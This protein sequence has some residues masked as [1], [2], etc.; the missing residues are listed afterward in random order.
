MQ[1]AALIYC[2]QPDEIGGE[3]PS[4]NLHHNLCQK[5]IHHLQ[6]FPPAS[7]TLPAC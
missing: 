1:T 7:I 4:V 3:S 5:P 6:K 2:L